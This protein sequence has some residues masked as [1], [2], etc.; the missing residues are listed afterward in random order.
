MMSNFSQQS[1]FRR[2]WSGS[3]KKLYV[4]SR[5]PVMKIIGRVSGHVSLSDLGKN[6][7]YGQI[8][9]LTDQEIARSKDLEQAIKMKW[10]DVIDNRSMILKVPV[11]AKTEQ[12]KDEMNK[13]EILNLAKEMA[14]TMVTEILNSEQSKNTQMVDELKSEINSLK[15]TID[16]KMISQTTII[17]QTGETQTSGSS[18]QFEEQELNSIVID[19]DEK[20]VGSTNLNNFGTEKQEKTDIS[21]SL[22]KMKKFRRK[23]SDDNM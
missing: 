20:E 15:K 21:S 13:D 9:E 5:A 10:V 16:E 7:A 14:K 11:T 17:N 19:V 6:V 2:N 1:L 8:V 3:T 4:E 18:L 22:E 23:P 12:K